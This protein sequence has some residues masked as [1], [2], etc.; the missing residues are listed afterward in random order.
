MYS[1]VQELKTY[2]GCGT[3]GFK[4]FQVTYF[5]G[6]SKTIG[7]LCGDLKTITFAKGEYLINTLILTDNGHADFPR[8][9]FFRIETN[10][11]VFT[12]GVDKQE[13]KTF[14]A[15]KL[16]LMGIYGLSGG[17]IDQLGFILSKRAITT[18]LTDIV[19]KFTFYVL[20]IKN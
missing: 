12:A 18:Q 4:G 1:P 13:Y 15:D 14:N 17:E 3:D 8:A 2:Y 19:C 7:T 9:G 5:D 20:N 10:L 6:S 11:Q 16:Y